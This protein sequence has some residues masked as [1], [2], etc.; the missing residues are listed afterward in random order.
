METVLIV[1]DEKLN[2]N[3]MV[4]LLKPTYKTL[5]AKNGEQALKRASGETLPDLIL[6]DVMMPEVDGYEVCRRLKA[7][8][9]T[10][11]IPVIFVT[12]LGE[13]GDEAKGFEVGAVDYIVKPISPA[14]VMARV[15]THLELKN[16]RDLL[17]NQNEVLEQKV[18]ERTRELAL[19]QDATIFSLASLAETRDPETGGHIRRTQHYVRV[20]AEHLK[21]HP[22]Y[23]SQ[24]DEGTIK[25]LFKSA[26]LHDIGKVGVPDNVLLKPGKLTDEE[27]ET[28]KRHAEWGRDALVHAQE[29]LGGTTTFLDHAV[30]IAHTHHEQWSGRGYPRGLK[31]DAIPL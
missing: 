1:D 31:E 18:E 24:L 16:A 22:D 29:A 20:L 14:L 5:V 13:V 15:R 10:L 19:T 4:E 25:L 27:F 11:D 12:A 7:D 28:M 17:K 3:V 30:D 9:S 21:T 23:A 6:L 8:A 2:L 26:P